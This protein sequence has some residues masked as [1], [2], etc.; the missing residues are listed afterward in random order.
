[1][2][3]ISGLPSVLF[4]YDGFYGL[5]SLKSRLSS[6]KTLCAALVV[7]FMLV[8]FIYLYVIIGFSLGDPQTSDYKNFPFL[9]R[10]PIIKELFEI[11]VSFASLLTLNSIILS[12]IPQLVAMHKIHNHPELRFL[13]TKIFY[14]RAL[15]DEF[16]DKFAIFVY[17][18]AQSII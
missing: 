9:N 4:I 17:L 7:G 12:N 16:E 13:K 18:I 2:I 11:L 14:K 3:I 6:N 8:T 10:N 15:D 5:A 1:M